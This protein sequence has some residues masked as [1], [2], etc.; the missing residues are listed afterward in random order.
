MLY[1]KQTEDIYDVSQLINV[2]EWRCEDDRP[3]GCDTELPFVN[4]VFTQEPRD[5]IRAFNR[6]EIREYRMP[7]EKLLEFDFSS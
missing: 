6:T 1:T 7:I 2:I 3:G 4:F 5:P